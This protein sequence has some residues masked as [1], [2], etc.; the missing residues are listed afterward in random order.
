MTEVQT[1]VDADGLEISYRRW[2]P[3]G[4]AKAIVQVAH[5]AS[6]H[7]ARYERFARFLAGRGYAVYANDHRGHGETAK[8]TGVG[9][10]GE[11]GWF[12]M[13]EDLHEFGA[14]ARR[15][16]PDV[17]VVLFGHSMGSFL[18]QRFAELY[19]EQ[20]AGL[21]LSG[22]S[23]AMTGL[24]DTIGGLDAVIEEAGGTAPAPIFAAFNTP[25]EPARTAFDWLSRDPVEVDAYVADPMCGDDAPLT[26]GFVRDMLQT[27]QDA[28]R[29]ENEARL[30]KSLP[31]LLVT[32]EADPVSEG[33]RTVRELEAR[34]RKLGLTNVTGLYY[35][36][37]R[38]EL[39]NETNR[40]E[41]QDDIVNWLDKTL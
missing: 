37:A 38:H 32:G 14:L 34:Y 10:A 18:A 27:L 13:V 36:D 12:G 7:S 26:L 5:G 9:V 16:V 17:P 25:F 21:V 35:P 20:L 6:E 40:D 15:D 41:V 22:S 24:E 39:L 2:L 23:G 28:W 11:R 31:V 3:D 4:T 1:F 8:V 33:A 30:P 19:G 29:P